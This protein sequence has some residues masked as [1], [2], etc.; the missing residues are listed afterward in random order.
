VIA[1]V[2]FFAWIGAALAFIRVGFDAEDRLRRPAALWCSIG[3]VIGLALFF[4]G[5]ARA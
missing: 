5:L 2:G 1:L 4:L 3:I